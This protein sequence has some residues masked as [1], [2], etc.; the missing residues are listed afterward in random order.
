[1]IKLLEILSKSDL[2]SIESFADKKLSPEDVEFSKHFFDRVNDPRNQKDISDAELIGFFKRL[3]KK[4]KQFIDFLNK[5]QEV[6]VSD[7]STNINIPFIKRVN[8]ILAKTVMRKKD[9][10]TSTKSIRI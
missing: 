4:K 5:Y 6:S 9:W 7:S 3:Q 10:K 8:D 1:M 2:D